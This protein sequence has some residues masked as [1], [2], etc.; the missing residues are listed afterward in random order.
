MGRE[1]FISCGLWMMFFIAFWMAPPA[2]AAIHGPESREGRVEKKKNKFLVLPILYYTP[3]TK[4]AGGVGGI[5]YWRTLEDRGKNRPSTFFTDLVYT[6]MKQIVFEISPNLYLKDG[7]FQLGG[8]MGFKKYV[9]KFYG[10]GSHTTDEM[11]EVY[12]YRSAKLMFSLRKKISPSFYMGVQYDFENYTITQVESGGIL[13]GGEILG[14]EGGTVSGL[15]IVLVQ[16]NRNNIFFPTKGSFLLVQASLFGQAFGSSYNFQKISIDFRQFVPLFSTHVLAFQQNINLTSG[17]V[18]F[19]WMSLLGGSSVMRGFIL[20]RF[21]DKNSISLQMEYRLP[22]IW[23][24]SAAGFIGFG[25]VADK[26]DRFRLSD[27]KVAG[28]LGI[29]YQL[30]RES[31]T[32]VRLDFGFA[33]G[34]FGVYATI[35]EAF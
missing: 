17:E 23:R 22:L 20:G 2:A 35:N 34:S 30:S 7:R 12:H 8:Y 9:E 13:E 3:E 10:I 15:G 25:N 26:W 28:G 16:D 5:F 6:Q 4:I 29:R 11:E 18:P 31:K 14:S 32:N 24:L 1:R 19:Q 33:K 21:R 27:F